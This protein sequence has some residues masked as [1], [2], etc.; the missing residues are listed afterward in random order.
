MTRHLAAKA[1][2]TCGYEAN[3]RHYSPQARKFFSKVKWREIKDFLRD[4][5]LTWPRRRAS[6]PRELK[7]HYRVIAEIS[8]EA[9][10]GKAPSLK[11]NPRLKHIKYIRLAPN[12]KKAYPERATDYDPIELD[13]CPIQPDIFSRLSLEE[14][15]RDASLSLSW[16]SSTRRDASTPLGERFSFAVESLRVSVKRLKREKT[17]FNPII[18]HRQ[19]EL[20]DSK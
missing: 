3:W 2:S 20:F 13:S 14:E 17:F 5:F 12:W 1:T 19:E 6:N 9:S 16:L 11:T 8:K 7:F 10:L 15:A 18:G 4:A